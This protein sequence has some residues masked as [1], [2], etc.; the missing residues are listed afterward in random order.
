[1]A[2]IRMRRQWLDGLAIGASS[3]CLVHCLALPALLVLLPALAAFIALPESFHLWALIAAV[4]MS[5]LAISIGFV[6]HRRWAPVVLAI[7]G[8]MC[9]GA[10]ELFF[11]GSS[12]EA[13]FAVLGSLQLGIAHALN[14]RLPRH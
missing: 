12:L 4:P 1:M 7:G 14:L 3:L 10:G 11:H 13:W 5:A 9:L 2:T 6:R 8:L